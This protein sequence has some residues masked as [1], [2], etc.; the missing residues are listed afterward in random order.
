[1]IKFIVT[2]WLDYLFAQYLA[3]DKSENR[4]IRKKEL[5]KWVQNFAK[6]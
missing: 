6:H 3:I 5:S 2:R 1:M 4:P